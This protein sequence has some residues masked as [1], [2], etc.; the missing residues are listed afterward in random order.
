MK[1][2]IK[3]IVQAVNKGYAIIFVI[4]LRLILLVIVHVSSRLQEHH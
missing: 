2:I 1:Q 3:L 4:T